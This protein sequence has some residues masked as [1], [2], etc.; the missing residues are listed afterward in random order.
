MQHQRNNL[1]TENS[2][3]LLHASICFL[4]QWPHPAPQLSVLPSFL[5]SKHNHYCNHVVENAHFHHSLPAIYLLGLGSLILRKCSR[6]LPF[7]LTIIYNHSYS[8]SEALQK[9]LLSGCAS[10]LPLSTPW[11]LTS[12]F[13]IFKKLSSPGFGLGR[14]APCLNWHLRGSASFHISYCILYLFLF[15]FFLANSLS[16]LSIFST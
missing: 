11:L 16:H 7:H 1:L 10:S 3:H 8:H 4:C 6:I 2:A 15:L 12:S 13:V 14:L 9:I 5:P